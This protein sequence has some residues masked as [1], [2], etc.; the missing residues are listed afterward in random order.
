MKE[1]HFE[2]G[3]VPGDTVR[4]LRKIPRDISFDVVI[5]DPPYNIGK[6]FGNNSDSMPIGEYVEW[7]REWLGSCFRLLA[8]GGLIYVYG[9][10]EILAHISVRYPIESQRWLVWRYTNRTVP[11]SRFWQRSHE[12][13]L[14][15]WKA[16]EKRPLLEVDQI[17]EPYT[18]NYIGRAGQKRKNTQGRYSRSGLPTIYQVHPNGALPRDVISVP[19][20]AGRAGA[21]ERWF[22]CMDCDHQV[23]HPEAMKDH[24]GHNTFKHPTQKPMALTRQLIRSRIAGDRGRILV[25]FSG[26]GSECLVAEQM[27]IAYRGIE[28]NPLYVDFSR[29]LIRNAMQEGAQMDI[30][31]EM[32]RN[33][34]FD[35]QANFSHVLTK[36]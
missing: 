17:R 26:S 31:V 19:A 11:A 16:D 9:F 23:F 34:D 35:D 3:I 28:I 15:L 8:P 5:A 4:E 20:L 27:G 14:C 24:R 32:K 6:D 18:K 36:A 33:L 29:K 13:I 22:M 30:L 12:S 7:T 1:V 25:P 10:A 2:S 21:T